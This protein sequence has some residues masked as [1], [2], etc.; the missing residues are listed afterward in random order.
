MY[1]SSRSLKEPG[2]FITQTFFPCFLCQ[3]IIKISKTEKK[4]SSDKHY[5][6]F[7]PSKI[8]LSGY[9]RGICVQLPCS[10]IF[11]GYTLNK[12]TSRVF[13]AFQQMRRCK[14]ASSQALYFAPVYPI[15]ERACNRYPPPSISLF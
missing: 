5:L 10:S 13:T 3:K 12:Y 15:R 2:R 6:I 14:M 8:L 9:E 4:H 11:S 7:T 1:F